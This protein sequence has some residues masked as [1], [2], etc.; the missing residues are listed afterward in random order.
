VVDVTGFPDFTR[1]LLAADTL[2]TDYSGA[3]FDFAHTDRPMI[4]LTP[5]LET[6]RDR[7]RG[8]YLDLEE[9]APGPVVRT[10]E[11]VLTCLDLDDRWSAA[12]HHLRSTYAPLDDGAVTKRLLAAVGDRL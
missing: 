11:D 8:L 5:D 12:R 3:M 10:T 4:F 9:L 1:L 6:Y 7:V 2:V